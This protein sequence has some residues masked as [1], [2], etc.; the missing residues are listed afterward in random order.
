MRTRRNLVLA[1]GFAGVFLAGALAGVFG[2]AGYVH[3]RLGALHSGDPHAVHALA[4]EW[5]DSRLDLAPE[6]SK[7]IESI[8]S[9]THAALF[10][11]KTEHNDELRAIVLP[12]LERVDA[13]LRPDQVERWQE[14]RDRIVEH[15]EATMETRDLRR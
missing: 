14:L 9:E 11:F 5:L 4:I 13:Q 12:A 1:L 7:A 3:H 10:R 15:V 6:Q 8:L 2:A